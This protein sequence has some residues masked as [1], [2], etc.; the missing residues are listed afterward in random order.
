[1]TELTDAIRA[2]G[3]WLIVIRPERFVPARVQYKDLRHVLDRCVVRL[4]GWDFPHIEEQHRRRGQDWIGG[5]TQWMYYRE[6]WRFYQSGQ[7]AY[8]LAI[9][10]D[11]VDEVPDPS[12]GPPHN[13]RT[14]GPLL[15]FGDTVDRFTETYELAAR[16]AATDAGD[17]RMVVDVRVRN[18]ARRTLWMDDPR[19]PPLP[20]VYRTD[21]TEIPWRRAYRREDLLADALVLARD[22]IREFMARFGL[23]DLQDATIAS[24]QGDHPFGRAGT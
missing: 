17:E 18:L 23:D 15:G 24:F 11:W 3:H 4:R 1:V 8:L 10:E 12:W 19:R 20:L 21:A 6:A 2:R 22:P 7:F 16:L 13:L 14:V 5:E 9:H